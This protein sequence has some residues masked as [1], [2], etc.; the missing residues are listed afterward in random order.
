MTM[1]DKNRILTKL[2]VLV[3]LAVTL[4]TTNGGT[5]VV[6]DLSHQPHLNRRTVTDTIQSTLAGRSDVNCI[7]LDV[8][9]SEMGNTG[10]VEMLKSLS[11]VHASIS[12]TS[13]MNRLT[14]HGARE[15]FEQLI[16][17][18]NAESLPMLKMS[19]L[20]LGW[21]NLHPDE[22]GSKAFLSS[23]RKLLESSNCPLHLRLDCCG[24]GPGACRAIGKVCRI[25][26]VGMYRIYGLR[27][28]I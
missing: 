5:T 16:T 19:S 11:S 13:R 8:S 20:D 26:F 27:H 17:E 15:V 22:D 1:A 24:L 28:R 25:F 4:H 2:L 9:N 18:T 10:L 7:D 21:N 6:F 23:L 14:P 3:V 12:L